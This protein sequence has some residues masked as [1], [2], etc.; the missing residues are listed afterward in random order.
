MERKII[1]TVVSVEAKDANACFVEIE[2]EALEDATALQ[3]ISTDLSF[4][5]VALNRAAGSRLNLICSRGSKSKV[6]VGQ[7][8]KIVVR[9]L[10]SSELRRRGSEN[11]SGSAEQA[12]DQTAK[13]V[14]YCFLFQ[15]RCPFSVLLRSIDARVNTTASALINTFLFRVIAP[16]H[17]SRFSIILNKFAEYSRGGAST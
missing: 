7:K 11:A 6:A 13:P 8:V 17:F 5:H 12:A 16:R 2:Y 1:G 10:E 14:G 4:E 9:P 3:V 15:F